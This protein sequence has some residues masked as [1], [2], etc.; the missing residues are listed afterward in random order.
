MIVQNIER[1]KASLPKGVGLVAVSKLKPLEDIM[2]AYNAGQRAFG[3]NYATELRDKAAVLPKDIE[4][5]FI[6]HLQ[7]KQIKYYIDFVHLIHGVDSLEHLEDVERAA[8]KAGRVVDVLLQVHVAQEETK[9]G[10]APEDLV[11][12]HEL[13]QLVLPHVRIRG[14]M[15]MA[16]HTDDNVRVSEDF[17]RVKTFFDNLK[18]MAFKD[19]PYFDTISMGMSHDYQLAVAEGSTLVRI[20][21]TIFG[22]RDYSKKQ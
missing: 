7:A 1:V 16:S 3:E 12:P 8:E 17:R 18:E 14:V 21:S 11:E 4:W 22:P 10:F 2:E 13:A 9:F 15:G 5:H 6:G 20:G 19:K